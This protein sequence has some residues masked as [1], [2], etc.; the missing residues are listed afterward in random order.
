[1]PTLGTG[2]AAGGTLPVWRSDVGLWTCVT[3]SGEH[4]E[5]DGADEAQGASPTVR[6]VSPDRQALVGPVCVRRP[7]RTGLSLKGMLGR[8]NLAHMIRV[9]MHLVDISPAPG[10][11]VANENSCLTVTIRLGTAC[12]LVKALQGWSVLLVAGRERPRL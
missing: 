11:V 2:T 12:H 8:L 4:S 5:V 3:S 10:A 6:H 7:G 9:E 1:M